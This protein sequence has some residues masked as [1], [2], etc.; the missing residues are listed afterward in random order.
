MGSIRYRNTVLSPEDLPGKTMLIRWEDRVIPVFC[1]DIAGDAFLGMQLR[2]RRENDDVRTC[3]LMDVGDHGLRE[4]S[5]AMVNRV[6][7]FRMD[8][9]V[10]ILGL[11]P[12]AALNRARYKRCQVERR[13]AMEKERQEVQLQIQREKRKGHR[14]KG[15]NKQ[16]RKLNRDLDGPQR[17]KSKSAGPIRYEKVNPHPM[18]GG[19]VSPK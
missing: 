12:P 3:W 1:Y 10:R 8:D 2:T 4:E 19:R 6:R 9:V 15:L 5:V 17:P 18:Q 14:T 7:R 13:P 11:V 16:L